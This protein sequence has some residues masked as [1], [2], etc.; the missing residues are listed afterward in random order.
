MLLV[1]QSRPG[2]IVSKMRPELIPIAL[3]LYAVLI[4]AAT[5]LTYAAAARLH[6]AGDTR[7]G[8]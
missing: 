1:V 3:M 6:W 5:Y 2:F 7:G 8:T 4:S